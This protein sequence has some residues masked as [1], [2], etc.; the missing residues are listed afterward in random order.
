MKKTK[1]YLIKMAK[2]NQAAKDNN[3]VQKRPQKKEL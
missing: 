2:H 3:K 1:D